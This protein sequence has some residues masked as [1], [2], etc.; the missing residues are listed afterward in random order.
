MRMYYE[1]VFDKKNTF[2]FMRALCF[3]EHLYAFGRYRLC[4]KQG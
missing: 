4:K 3:A 1:K 2:R